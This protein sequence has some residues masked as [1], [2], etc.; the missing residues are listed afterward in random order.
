MKTPLITLVLAIGLSF[1]V[2]AQKAKEKNIPDVVLNTV[3]NKYPGA[4]DINWEDNGPDFKARFTTDKMSHRI[5]ITANGTITK[6]QEEIPKESLPVSVTNRVESEFK[7]LT[8]DQAE[9]IW[10]SDSRVYYMV[11]LKGDPGG[12]RRVT[13]N[14]DGTIEANKLD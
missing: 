3:H 14:N 9:K 13:F 4:Q 8:I 7:G 5:W 12:D 2:M 10:Y 6:V 11:N 1:S